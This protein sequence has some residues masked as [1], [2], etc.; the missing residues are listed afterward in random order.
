M[1]LIFGVF[2]EMCLAELDE[3]GLDQLEALLG[4]P[5]HDVFAWL[6]GETAVPMAFDNA[7]FAQMW[8]LCRR[9]SPTWNV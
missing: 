7:V 5:D 3:T 8:A 4:A 1:D 2:A 9:K 6:Q